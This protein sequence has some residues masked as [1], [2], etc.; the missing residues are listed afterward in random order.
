MDK[1][2]RQYFSSCYQED[3]NVWL[4]N[5]IGIFSWLIYFVALF[6]VPVRVFF[7]C[8]KKVLTAWHRAALFE[9]RVGAD[10]LEFRFRRYLW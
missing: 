10:K 3:R 6:Y 9:K 8:L 7:G 2:D 4:K 5:L 1:Y